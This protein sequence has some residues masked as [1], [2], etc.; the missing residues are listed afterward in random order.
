MRFAN[1]ALAVL[2]QLL[3]NVLRLSLSYSLDGFFDSVD[4]TFMVEQFTCVNKAFLKL[5]FLHI[6]QDLEDGLQ[7]VE[8]GQLYLSL[9]RA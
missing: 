6:L 4:A 3:L 8:L 2:I 5:P 1:E 9:P 7:A